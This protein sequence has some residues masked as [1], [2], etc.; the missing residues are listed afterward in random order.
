M[1]CVD[2]PNDDVI[3]SC[4]SLDTLSHVSVGEFLIVQNNPVN[5]S[6]VNRIQTGCNVKI[7]YS[8]SFIRWPCGLTYYYAIF[9]TF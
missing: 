5:S 3:R 2:R 6:V 9:I 8:L 1:S 7:E 4:L